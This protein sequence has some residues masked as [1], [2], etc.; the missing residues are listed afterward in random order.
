MG[1]DGSPFGATTSSATF[2]FQFG[3]VVVF[4]GRRADGWLARLV[5]SGQ[6]QIRFCLLA[7][8]A[9]TSPP[10]VPKRLTTPATHHTTPLRG[11]SVGC[12]RTGTQI[13][14]TLQAE[15]RH[16]RSNGAHPAGSP[17]CTCI[18][19]E[20]TPPPG[21]RRAEEQGGGSELSHQPSAAGRAQAIRW[22]LVAKN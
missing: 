20:Q 17:C 15:P 19:P 6:P 2:T 1:W 10:F 11:E 16:C 21:Q 22:R 13:N 12:R 14:G 8:D 4:G 18:S 7:A 3:S 5:R 9:A